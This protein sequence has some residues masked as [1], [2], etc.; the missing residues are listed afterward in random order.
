MTEEVLDASQ[1]SQ[2]AVLR[3]A[4]CILILIRTELM[5]TAWILQN[6]ST[7]ARDDLTVHGVL[8]YTYKRLIVFVYEQD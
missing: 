6:A 7:K 3:W 8:M 2:F 5:H 4:V 1:A